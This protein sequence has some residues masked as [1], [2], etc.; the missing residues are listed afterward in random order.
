MFNRCTHTSW[1]QA[2]WKKWELTGP[3]NNNNN[4]S[5]NQKKRNSENRIIINRWIEL[6]FYYTRKFLLFTLFTHVLLLLL[7]FTIFVVLFCDVQCPYNIYIK[8]LLH[9]KMK[10]RRKKGKFSQLKGFPRSLH[11]IFFL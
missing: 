5:K 6:L 2:D 9:T 10:K 4:T 3:T 1:Y 11:I 7:F 8:L